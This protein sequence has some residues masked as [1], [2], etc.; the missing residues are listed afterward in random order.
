MRG[1]PFS[2]AMQPAF[3]HCASG[4]RASAAWMIKRV[5]I[6]RWDVEKA[7]AEAEAMNLTDPKFKQFA[8]DYVA[9]HR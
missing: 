9:K 3:I 6:D 5:L 2:Q 7:T 8:L 4:I 1:W